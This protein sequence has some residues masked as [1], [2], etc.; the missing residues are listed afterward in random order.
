[1]PCGRP[2]RRSCLPRRA[3]H[4]TDTL[5]RAPLHTIDGHVFPKIYQDLGVSTRGAK[6]T[7][8]DGRAAG[9]QQDERPEDEQLA[10]ARTT[11]ALDGRPGSGVGK[12]T[13]AIVVIVVI[14]ILGE[15]VG[16]ERGPGSSVGKPTHVIVVV[17][18]I[19][20]LCG[21]TKRRARLI[22]T[23][24]CRRRDCADEA[25]N[26]NTPIAVSVQPCYEKKRIRDSSFSQERS[27]TGNIQQN[28][29]PMPR[30]RIVR[31][32]ANRG[33]TTPD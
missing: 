8:D 23:S 14:V 15:G 4:E 13:H 25:D 16:L 31:R 26:T 11:T 1:M 2:D 27:L 20:V 29:L 3:F 17:I 28:P 7:T 12:P 24:Q 22:G 9:Q 21:Q 10:C 30:V 6:A 19:V 18:V 33:A 32:I 5:F